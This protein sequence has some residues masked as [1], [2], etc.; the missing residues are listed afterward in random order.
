VSITPEEFRKGAL[1]AGLP[2]WLVDAL[3]VLN[4][5]F[6]AGEASVVTNVVREV[7]GREPIGFD[8]FARDYAG[9]FGGGG[10]SRSG[11]VS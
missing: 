10:R 7:G 1:A 8:K 11:E 6:A 2:E 5:I 4:K 3:E 9:A